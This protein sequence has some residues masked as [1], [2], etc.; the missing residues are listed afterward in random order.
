MMTMQ[1]GSTQQTTNLVVDTGSASMHICG[2]DHSQ[3]NTSTDSHESG[4]LGYGS[5][6]VNV[7]F[8]GDS[9]GIQGTPMGTSGVSSLSVGSWSWI[10]DSGYNTSCEA[11]GSSFTYG[12]LVGLAPPGELV[13][14]APR[15]AA[16][17]LPRKDLKC[18]GFIE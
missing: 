9:V 8:W 1:F 18:I 16:Y 4:I 12:G 2:Y 13:W 7:S 6:P 11:D 5:S 17:W 15:L 10:G 3:S 14:L